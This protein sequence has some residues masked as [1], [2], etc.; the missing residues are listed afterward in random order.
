[1]KTKEGIA[2][3]IIQAHLKSINWDEGDMALLEVNINKGLAEYAKL[4]ISKCG[5]CKSLGEDW[6]EE[7]VCQCTEPTGINN[8][9]NNCLCFGKYK[10]TP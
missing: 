6:E 5:I 10:Y 7:E 3:S 2:K 4:V 9:T 1:M 8:G